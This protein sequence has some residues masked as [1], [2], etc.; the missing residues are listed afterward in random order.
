M[1]KLYASR[2][3]KWLALII[4]L[5]VPAG[6]LLALTLSTASSFHS[7]AQTGSTA[8]GTRDDTTGTVTTPASGTKERR[9]A[10]GTIAKT[11][12]EEASRL[13]SDSIAWAQKLHELAVD[14]RN[15][16]PDVDTTARR[17]D[18]CLVVL[19]AVATRLAPNSETRISL[20]K[21]EDAIRDLASRAEVHAEQSVRKNA[22]YF[23]QKTSELHAL[24]RSMEETRI[25]LTAQ[26]D[27]LQELKEQL[28]FN[29]AAAHNGEPLKG[30]QGSVE[31]L[32]A[33]T[34]D[35][36][37][38]ANNLDSFGGNPAVTAKPADV[39]K[40]AEATKRR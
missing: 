18:E 7:D 19:R 40:P 5:R 3:F 31:H 12:M 4:P 15:N 33:L 22:D 6:L 23:Q 11:I 37:R 25:Q 24:N 26:I 10:P 21:Q 13:A 32:Q 29:H 36:Q 38:L 39:G 28:E 34:A 35:A 14:V 30:A 17:V 8:P 1:S 9:F 27:Q 2:G 16:A 20:R